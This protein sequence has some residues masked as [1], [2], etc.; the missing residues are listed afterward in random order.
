MVPPFVAPPT[1]GVKRRRWLAV[2]LAGGAAVLCC[3]GGVFGLGGLLV[4]GAQ[5]SLDQSR[6]A[7]T[8]FLTEVQEGHLISAYQLLCADEQ[9]TSSQSM[10]EQ[11]WGLHPLSSFTVGEPVLADPVQVP[12]TL[13]FAGGRTEQVTYLTEQDPA[14]GEFEVCGQEG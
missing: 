10:F 3:A 2:G 1:D 13:R 4:F 7:V 9:S 14:T 5:A 6:A 11:T 12:A 8:E